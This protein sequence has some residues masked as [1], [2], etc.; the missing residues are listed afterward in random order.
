[1][2]RQGR[3]PY[4]GRRKGSRGGAFRCG[5]FQ[6]SLRGPEFRRRDHRLSGEEGSCEAPD[7]EHRWHLGWLHRARFEDGPAQGDTLQDGLPSRP[8]P[9]PA[10]TPGPLQGLLEGKGVRRRY[11]GGREHGTRGAYELRRP[12]RTG[13]D[14]GRG[15]RLREE[16]RRQAFG[17]GDGT[18]VRVHTEVQ[19]SGGLDRSLAARQRYSRSQL[20]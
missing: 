1:M 19:D 3:E 15:N 14:Q 2:V 6:A 20:T 13:I 5:E 16:E 9:R 7:V 11:G 8:E 18:S 17:A 4:G 12:L 10:G